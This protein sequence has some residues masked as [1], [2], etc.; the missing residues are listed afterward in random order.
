MLTM[1]VLT[2]PQKIPNTEHPITTPNAYCSPIRPVEALVAKISADMTLLN[3][4][5]KYIY[6][7]N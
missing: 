4:L 3:L 7:I 2:R 6:I 1:R 5:I